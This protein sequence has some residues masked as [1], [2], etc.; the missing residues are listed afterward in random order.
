MDKNHNPNAGAT[1]P[2][3]D[4][5]KM[6]AAHKAQNPNGLHAEYFGREHF[7]KLLAIPGTKGIM[8]HRGINDSGQ[9]VHILDA[10]DGNL[11]TV[12]TDPIEQGQ[13]C[14][15]FCNTI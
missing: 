6:A 14:P 10:V 3:A 1:I 11:N 2:R 7:E 15:P 12:S 13:P 4:A 9:Q 5:R 8:I